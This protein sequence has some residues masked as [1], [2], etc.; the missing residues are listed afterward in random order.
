MTVAVVKEY[1]KCS[2]CK[3][4]VIKQKF[5][6]RCGNV[7][8]PEPESPPQTGEEKNM[9]KKTSENPVEVV[10][11]NPAEQ[12]EKLGEKAKGLEEERRAT[13]EKELRETGGKKDSEKKHKEGADEVTPASGEGKNLVDKLDK[14][15]TV[16]TQSDEMPM[17][18]ESHLIKLL[19]EDK[20]SDEAF[21]KLYNQMA[22]DAQKL[23]HRRKELIDEIEASIKGYRTSLI[24]VQQN[25]K[26]LNLRARAA[27]LKRDIDDYKKGI[28][29][30]DQKA[31]YLRTLHRLNDSE[32]LENLV[33]A[34]NNCDDALSD[35]NLS[36]G[37]KD[38]IHNSMK[39]ALDLLQ[40][41]KNSQ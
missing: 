6:P 31:T 21:L 40:E 25:M 27:A 29:D 8:I 33:S 16:T 35:L 10:E 34:V 1:V 28:T 38:K 4:P 15:T 23:V 36:D 24:S 18:N 3:K 7:L 17:I 11:A 22:D 32:G 5:C 2:H 12:L 19:N 9:D 37:I 30:E 14:S 39:E 26:L 41:T 13:I 20:I